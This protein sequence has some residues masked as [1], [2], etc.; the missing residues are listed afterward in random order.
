MD[1][2][3]ELRKVI[4]A[5]KE[6]RAQ[7]EADAMEQ[8]RAEQYKDITTK[9]AADEFVQTVLPGVVAEMRPMVR[10]MWAGPVPIP[11]P[12]PP[13]NSFHSDFNHH[14]WIYSFRVGHGEALARA[15]GHTAA[16]TIVD[17]KTGKK[18]LLLPIPP[19]RDSAI[20]TFNT[21]VEIGLS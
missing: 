2:E 20:R 21:V 8:H 17:T 3:E 16:L 6:Q 14:D 4:A 9:Q 18:K 12:G 5:V 15:C 11:D 13:N 19:T 7:A 1:A 10:G